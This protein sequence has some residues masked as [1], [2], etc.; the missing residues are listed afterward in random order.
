MEPRLIR[1]PK[2][3]RTA[4]FALSEALEKLP[5]V[6][7]QDD[8]GEPD[9]YQRHPDTPVWNSSENGRYC[10]RY[11][12]ALLAGRNLLARGE[13]CA[14]EAAGHARECCRDT[15]EWMAASRIED[16]AA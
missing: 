1:R 3:G 8:R 9:G 7:A 14:A 15:R 13:S 2:I 5:L 4:L 12:A 6:G 11:L 16:D 10:Y